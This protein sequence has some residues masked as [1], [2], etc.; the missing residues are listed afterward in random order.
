MKETTELILNKIFLRFCK[1]CMV[2]GGENLYIEIGPCGL[3][4]D[5]PYGFQY[6]ILIYSTKIRPFLW[7]QIIVFFSVVL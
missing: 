7:R 1:E 6:M 5:R 4:Y 3:T 2:N